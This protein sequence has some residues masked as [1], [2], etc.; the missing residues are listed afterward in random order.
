MKINAKFG[1]YQFTGRGCVSSSSCQANSFYFASQGFG[2]GCC[3]SN[4]CNAAGSLRVEYYA[5]IFT[6]ILSVFV[7]I[8]NNF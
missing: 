6:F 4:D 2:V 8:L 1:D 7:Q 3:T 5:L